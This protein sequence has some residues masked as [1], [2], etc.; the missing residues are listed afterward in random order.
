MCSRFI[1]AASIIVIS[2][3]SLAEDAK[4]IVL[5]K[6]LK[7]V[8]LNCNPSDM[9]VLIS[10]LTVAQQLRERGNDVVVFADLEAAAIGDR[11]LRHVPNDR[12]DEVRK[13]L[14]RLTDAGVKLLVCPH[15]AKR[16]DLHSASLRRGASMINRA[17]LDE[18]KERADQIFEYR[19]PPMTQ[20]SEEDPQVQGK[21][22]VLL[23]GATS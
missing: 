11:S 17:Q 13:L 7:C 16:I 14:D 5:P 19:E 3:V 2:R 8:Q 18:L 15:C 20:P 23:K 12:R 10:T 22:L 4:E 1:L 21:S 6:P 9:R